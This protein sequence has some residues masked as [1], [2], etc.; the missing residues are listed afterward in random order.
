[1]TKF[2]LFVALFLGAVANADTYRPDA[3]TTPPPPIYCST[4]LPPFPTDVYITGE[5][6]SKM[7]TSFQQQY[8]SAEHGCGTSQLRMITI[9]R[10]GCIYDPANASVYT[11]G[12][13]V[14]NA[15]NVCAVFYTCPYPRGGVGN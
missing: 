2:I 14:D 6:A 1:M 4:Q 10:V 5:A 8:P 13:W 12:M 15:G 7:Y 11:C 3:A 9:G